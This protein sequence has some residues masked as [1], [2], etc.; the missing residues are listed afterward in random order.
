MSA[1]RTKGDRQYS[2]A[3]ASK[4]EEKEAVCMYR[5]FD[6]Y[7]TSKIAVE[8]VHDNEQKFKIIAP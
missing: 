7:G 4:G 6:K 5:V 8:F 1:S 2:W 3:G